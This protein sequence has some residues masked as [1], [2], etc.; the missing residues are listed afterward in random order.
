MYKY[1][2]KPESV[3]EINR[4]MHSL[5]E[6]IQNKMEDFFS[7]GREAK[8]LAESAQSP[9][10]LQEIK[11]GM[12]E[13]INDLKQVDCIVRKLHPDKEMHELFDQLLKLREEVINGT[14]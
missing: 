12:A 9:E 14:K 5:E 1:V 6:K 13:I 2:I 11:I 10:K 4:L 7:L 8:R 3:T